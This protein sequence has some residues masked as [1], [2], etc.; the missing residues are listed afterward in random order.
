MLRHRPLDGRAVLFFALGRDRSVRGKG[1]QIDRDNQQQQ[2]HRDAEQESQLSGLLQKP[3]S[4][5]AQQERQQQR[6]AW[7][8]DQV[9]LGVVQ[10]TRVVE[11]Q[12]GHD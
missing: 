9:G 3:R 5:S 2:M 12:L 11:P 6:D 1:D 8:R 10:Q 7:D 4:Q